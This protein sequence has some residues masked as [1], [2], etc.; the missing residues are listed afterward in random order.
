MN[1]IFENYH[2]SMIHV[3]HTKN[4][5]LDDNDWD[6][7]VDN[8]GKY[9]KEG[10]YERKDFEGDCVVD[11]CEEAITDLMEE[12]AQD[13]FGWKYGSSHNKRSSAECLAEHILDKFY[14]LA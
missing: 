1:K 13:D 12:Y 11:I 10:G 4:Q 14:P 6:Y 9:L 2:P 3:A 8:V 7:L 5:L